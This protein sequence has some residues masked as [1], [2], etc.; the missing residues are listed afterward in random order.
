MKKE[1]RPGLE[2]LKEAILEIA[3]EVKYVRVSW[4]LIEG[5]WWEEHE[6]MWYD[7][8]SPVF[9]LPLETDDVIEYYENYYNDPNVEKG[10][11]KIVEE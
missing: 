1:F 8:C 3:K 7:Y 6:V 10:S 11:L 9:T 5:E 2:N 4:K